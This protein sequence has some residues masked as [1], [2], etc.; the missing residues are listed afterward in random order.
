MTL[1]DAPVFDEARDKR[2]RTIGIS[3]AGGLVL[4]FIVWWIVAGKPIDWP[5]RWN[6]HLVGRIKIN[7][8][9]TDIEKNDLNAAY[10]VWINDKNWQQHP[11][12][13]ANSF[14]RF[15]EGWDPNSPDAEWQG[16][17]Q[18]HHIASHRIYGNVLLVAILI[19]GA[20]QNALNLTYDPRTGQ[21]SYAPPG[22]KLSIDPFKVVQ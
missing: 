6:T 2:K 15:K 10:G 1:L 22:V 4:L 21:V 3:V 11:P 16:V 9:L 12:H 5:W 13:G 18:S 7:R 19:N 8:F 20:K 17:I 14:E